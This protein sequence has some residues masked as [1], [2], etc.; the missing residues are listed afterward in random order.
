MKKALLFC[1]LF[2]VTFTIQA[3]STSVDSLSNSNQSHQ[4]ISID[5][6]NF[7]IH[8]ISNNTVDYKSFKTK[9]DVGFVFENCVVDP[10]SMAKARTNNQ[11]V[12]NFLSDKYGLIWKKELPATPFGVSKIEN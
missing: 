4:K 3:Q 2:F 8:G 6:S 7:I 10:I 9:Y 12:A 1:L 11:T 5:S